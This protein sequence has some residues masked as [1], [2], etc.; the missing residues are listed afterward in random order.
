MLE[1]IT[2]FSTAEGYHRACVGVLRTLCTEL[3]VVVYVGTVHVISDLRRRLQV[4]EIT[5][6]ALG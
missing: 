3:Q 5:T 4:D 2:G 6:H 1:Y